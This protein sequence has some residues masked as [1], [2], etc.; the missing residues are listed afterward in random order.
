MYRK[1]LQTFL[2]LIFS[3]KDTAQYLVHS[4][5]TVI[6]VYDKEIQIHTL[7]Y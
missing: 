7:K 5:E 6:P 1:R 3:N 2:P 4:L